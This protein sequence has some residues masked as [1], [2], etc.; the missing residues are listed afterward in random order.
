MPTIMR[1]ATRGEILCAA[2]RYSSIEKELADMVII[3]G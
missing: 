3:L 1:L 2:R